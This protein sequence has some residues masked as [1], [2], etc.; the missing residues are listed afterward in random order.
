MQDPKP[1]KRVKLYICKQCKN[2]YEKTNPNPLVNWCSAE[3]GAKIAMARLDKQKQNAKKAENKAWKDRKQG[4]AQELG[5]KGKQ[6]NDPLQ[7]VVNKIARLLDEDLPCLARPNE[8]V[9]W[10][11]GGHIFSTLAHPSI[12][13]HLWN[14]HKQ[15]VKSNRDL[16]GESTLMLEGIENRYGKDRREFIGSLPSLYPTLQLASHEKDEALKKARQVLRLIE[17]GAILTRDEVNNLI[18]IYKPSILQ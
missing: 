7:R 15:S 1:T 2:K 12:R 6:T 9:Q 10:F 17:G 11:D 8:N 13:F 4:L 5:K 3:C 16:G 14:I 18:G